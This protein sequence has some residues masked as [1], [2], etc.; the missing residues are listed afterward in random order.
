M[1]RLLCLRQWLQG[2]GRDRV[3]E[4]G[5][6]EL[7]VLSRLWQSEPRTAA[8]LVQE[9]GVDTIA[10]STVQSTLE[11]LHRK[12]MVVRKKQGRAFVYFASLTRA[13]L[14]SLILR[15]LAEEF[16]D[17]D[18]AP[19]FSGFADFAAGQDPAIR[20]ELA[21]LLGNNAGEEPDDD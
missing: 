18:P 16:G 10:L 7:D 21:R 2:K 20:R 11:R 9:I 17:G 13:Q 19:L 3:P 12:G 4:L 1:A 8:E 14:I 15:D 5:P 6:R